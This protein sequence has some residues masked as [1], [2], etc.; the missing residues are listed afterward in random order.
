MSTELRGVL[1]LLDRTGRAVVGGLEEIGFGAGLLGGA[2]GWTVLIGPRRGQ[3]VRLGAVVGEAVEIGLKALPIVAL[4]SATIGVMLAIQGIH[5]LRQFGAESQVTYGIALSVVREF[6]PLITGILVAGRSGSALAAR[7]G[8]MK[9]NQEI[10]ALTAM[11]IDPLRY[12]VAPALLAMMVMLPALALVADLV[13]LA[14]AG[15]YVTF[16]LGI[17][18]AAYVD[19]VREAL[20]LGDLLHG[21]GKAALFAVLVAV[22]GVVNGAQV[23]GGAQ[24]VGR[25]TTRAVVHAIS[26]IVMTDMIFVFLVTR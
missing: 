3:P 5:S 15:L 8:T 12:L 11:G 19:R 13:A 18:M 26:A 10:D 21:L 9:I 22:I 25:A 6:A 2:L 16:E 20:A 14:G 17:S 4:L 1:G 24:G 7:I 23:R